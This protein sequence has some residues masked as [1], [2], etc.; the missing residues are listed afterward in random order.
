MEKSPKL[1]LTPHPTPHTPPTANIHQIRTL[2]SN[3]DPEF[4]WSGAYAMRFQT[5]L[6]SPTSEERREILRDFLLCLQPFLR[7]EEETSWRS[8]TGGSRLLSGGLSP[9]CIVTR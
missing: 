1:N 4:T 2:L 7:R 9:S 8:D 5:H 6:G 3:V